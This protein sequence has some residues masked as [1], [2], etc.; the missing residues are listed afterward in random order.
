MYIVFLKKV[1]TSTNTHFFPVYAQ[2]TK[3]SLAFLSWL[4]RL[5]KNLMFNLKQW[6][7]ANFICIDWELKSEKSSFPN[8]YTHMH[9]RIV[10]NTP[11]SKFKN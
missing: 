11:I 1:K 10:A 6:A 9:N 8:T 4:Y 5:I 2:Y 3:K 7:D